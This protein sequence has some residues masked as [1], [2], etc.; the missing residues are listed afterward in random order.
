MSGFSG[1]RSTRHLTAALIAAVACLS[2]VATAAQAW[3]SPA[4]GSQWQWQLSGGR[5]DTSFE[6]PI[7]DLDV[8]STP[9]SV[10]RALH[11][12][13]RRVVCYIDAGSW[14]NYRGDR[15]AYAPSLLGRRVAGWPAERWVDIRRLD[16][17]AGPTGR[18]LRQILIARID[19][20]RTKGFDAVEPDWMDSYTQ[21]TGFTI[22][23]RQQLRFNRF[24]AS[25][26]HTRG[27]GVALKNDKEQT[28]ALVRYFDFGIDEECQHWHEC[29]GRG[30]S[31]D[32]GWAP[33]IAAGK[34]VLNAE[35]TDQTS[36]CAQPRGLS[37]ILKHRNL[38]N[39]R[40]QCP[41]RRR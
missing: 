18:T 7:Y 4:P 3:W 29:L 28:R 36:S 31:D 11:A 6:V 13:G 38:G 16:G 10:V 39:W 12:E 14:E 26:A 22:S 2:G 5:I 9:A 21:K 34:A 23:A 20:C 27:L 41:A 1:R 24:L 8:D 30:V 40:A 25:A 15:R 17:P 35:Y 19:R 37:S 32:P 33:F